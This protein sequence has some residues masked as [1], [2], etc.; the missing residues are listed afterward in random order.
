MEKSN[1]LTWL[2]GSQPSEGGM[3]V[4]SVMCSFPRIPPWWSTV[5]Q[6]SPAGQ[7]LQAD[8]TNRQ[9]KDVKPQLH[10]THIFLKNFPT[11]VSI[12]AGTEELGSF[13]KRHIPFTG[14]D[15]R[16]W[17]V[18]ALTTCWKTRKQK[19]A[20]ESLKVVISCPKSYKIRI[21]HTHYY[22]GPPCVLSAAVLYLASNC[23]FQYKEL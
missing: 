15:T 2:V 17:T 12:P 20:P 3:Q 18:E 11:A 16:S 19:Q 21:Y 13:Q 7:C 5:Q 14:P 9:R 10:Y 1:V 6:W 8:R 23:V 4:E 22:T